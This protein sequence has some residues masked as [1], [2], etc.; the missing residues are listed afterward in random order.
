MKK[1]TLFLTAALFIT[2]LQ[3]CTNT[4]KKLYGTWKLDTKQS[5]DL[6][7]WRYRQLE[8]NIEKNEQ[9]VVSIVNNWLQR[10]KVANIDSMAFVPGQ[11]VTEIPVTSQIW[12]ENWYMGV[13]AKL[14]TM[15]KAS[16]EWQEPDRKLAVT[17]EL[18]VE[19]SQGDTVFE[20]TFE[21]S[22]DRR[23]DTMTIIEKRST[24]PTPITLVLTRVVE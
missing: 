20:T 23:G 5:T 10:G 22:L 7:T 16:G 19:V 12:P 11:G 18:T 2:L 13:L 9:G 8:V 1:L 24:R 4:D 14:G 3:S 17:R 21:Y 15:K 6:V